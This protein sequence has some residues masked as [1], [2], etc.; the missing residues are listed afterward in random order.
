MILIKSFLTGVLYDCFKL[1]YTLLN[2]RDKVHKYYSSLK[3]IR[4]AH[5]NVGFSLNMQNSNNS[6]YIWNCCNQTQIF[7]K[8]H[9][10]SCH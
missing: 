1:V 2:E 6:I 7:K 8:N 4:Q 3:M 5:L 9:E 10:V